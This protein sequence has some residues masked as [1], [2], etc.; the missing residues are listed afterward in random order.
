MCCVCEGGEGWES[1]GPW[2]YISRSKPRNRSS[3]GRHWGWW[4]E[5]AYGLHD[6]LRPHQA[7]GAVLQELLDG[8]LVLVPGH[9]SR[10]TEGKTQRRQV[11]NFFQFW[12]TVNFE[13]RCKSTSPRSPSC[14]HWLGLCVP[15]PVCLCA[16]QEM[17]VWPLGQ[18]DPLATHASILAWGI[19]RTEEPGGLQSMGW[20]RVGHD[21]ATKHSTRSNL[22][23][24]WKCISS[25]FSV[26]HPMSM[27]SKV[28]LEK[29][30]SAQS[31][32]ASLTSLWGHL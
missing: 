11:V 27:P 30:A 6:E 13:K 31:C 26:T 12:K 24:L 7:V 2:V 18:E 14:S 29:G 32:R 3:C 4:G 22:D 19:P 10:L 17:Q 20:Q 9:R 8:V 15:S 16:S 21:W 28:P 23:E 5:R 1:R 25:I